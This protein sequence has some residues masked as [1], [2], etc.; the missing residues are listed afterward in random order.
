M[1]TAS[2][3]SLLFMNSSANDVPAQSIITKNEFTVVAETLF[4][5]SLF[6]RKIVYYAVVALWQGDER[7]RP[8]GFDSRPGIASGVTR[9]RGEPPR[10]TLFRK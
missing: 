9:G 1:H 8:R 6:R 7:S 10:V 4:L 3:R 2:E 5:F